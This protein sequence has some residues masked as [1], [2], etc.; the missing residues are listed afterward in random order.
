MKIVW[1]EK[2][3]KQLDQIF[4][5]IAN[6]SPL[7]AHRTVNKI[8]AKVELIKINPQIG[9]K[10]PEFDRKDMREIFCYSYRI[11]YRLKKNE[12]NIISI[13]HGARLLPED[14]H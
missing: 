2:A 8:I 1:S 6:D 14:L 7:Y 3:E 4:N 5:Y 10:V 9:R 13:I 12:I 11:I